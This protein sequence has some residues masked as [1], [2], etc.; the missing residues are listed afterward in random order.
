MANPAPALLTDET[1]ASLIVPA[2]TSAVTVRDVL[3]LP[4]FAQGDPEV[5]AGDAGLDRPLRWVHSGEVRHI[6]GLLKGGE[7]L[8]TTGLGLGNAIEQRQFVRDLAAR[9][10]AALVVELGTRF[11]RAPS[12]LVSEAQRLGLPVILLNREIPFVEVTEQVHRELL[13]RQHELLRRGEELH[14]R[15]TQLMIAGAGIPEVLEQLARTVG[16]PV[17]LEKDGTGLV[18][19]ATG[20]ADDRAVLAAWRALSRARMPQPTTEDRPT[21]HRSTERGKLD[22]DAAE[23]PVPGPNG[24][25]WGRLVVIEIDRPI[26]PWTTVAVERAVGLISL[27]LLREYAEHATTTRER[28]NFLGALVRGEL[29]EAA[30]SQRAA[31]IGFGEHRGQLLS[32]VAAL[33]R[34]VVAIQELE[35]PLLHIWRDVA[36]E[37][38]SR[39]IQ[40]IAGTDADE[41]ELLIVIGVRAESV[42]HDLADLLASA[43]DRSAGRRLDSEVRC[44]LAVGPVATGWLEAGTGLALAAETVQAAA[45]LTPR[46]WHD[47]TVPELDVLWLSWRERPELRR[48]VDSRLGPLTDHDRRHGAHLI[49]TLAALCEH[50]GRKAE[51]ARALHIERQSLYHRL[52]R[53]EEILGVDLGDPEVLFAL[54]LAVR[55][56]QHQ[57]AD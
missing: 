18:Y 27:A 35:D 38:E 13:D 31:A 17:V 11:R 20:P 42:R 53:I 6:A 51:T 15:F 34:A 47:A 55:A 22:M 36:T 25:H 24:S 45:H 50:G 2:R 37:L 7:L 48:F 19:H 12:A 10:I 3:E 56:R 39:R 9:R 32:A 41:R 5:A 44:V 21:S 29:S 4:V 52:S 49:P 43:V 8:M 46:R 54:F 23:Q 33:P 26:D 1:V 14:R 40:A 28:G 16:N 30:A 57:P